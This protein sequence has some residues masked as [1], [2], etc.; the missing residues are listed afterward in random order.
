LGGALPIGRIDKFSES[1][2]NRRVSFIIG[3]QKEKKEKYS[4]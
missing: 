2:I 4:F 3:Y 1:I